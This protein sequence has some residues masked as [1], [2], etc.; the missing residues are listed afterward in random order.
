MI[1]AFTGTAQARPPAP[2]GLELGARLAVQV[3]DQGT[4]VIAGVQADWRVMPL[5]ALGVYFDDT[6]AYAP[7][8]YKCGCL[9]DPDRPSRLGG[10]GELHL[11]PNSRIDPWLRGGL[12]AVW[13]NHTSADAEL[14]AGLDFRGSFLALGPFLAHIAPLGSGQPETWWYAGARLSLAF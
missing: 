9:P 14:G 3:S 4:G 1:L 2:E 7:T 8:R 12:G 13:T 5:V 6:P 10:F 11:M